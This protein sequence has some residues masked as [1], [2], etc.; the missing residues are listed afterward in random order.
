MKSTTLSL[1]VIIFAL[2]FQLFGCSGGGGGG[3]DL[4][5]G[6]GTVTP[7]ATSSSITIAK[8]V[9]QFGDS[10]LVT[11]SITA[12]TG[13]PAA[14]IAVVF[15]TTLGTLT[16][17]NGIAVT[18]ANGVASV[19]LIAGAN[20]GQGQITASA[21]IDNKQLSSTTSFSVNLPPL[22]LGPLN[23]DLSTISYGGS[24]TVSVQV[25]D[26]NGN[27]Y[28]TQPVDVAFISTQ[29]ALGNASI[30]PIV[31]TVNGVASATYS[32]L[33][34]TGIDTITAAIAG[35]TKTANITILPLNAG[36]ISFVSAAP[37][38]IVQK[39]MAAP[40][41]SETSL[42]TFKVLDT[43]GL[44]KANQP[45][46]FTLTASA[47]DLGG[48]ALL[49]V[50]SSSDINGLV[51]TTVQAGTESTPFRVVATV[52]GTTIASQSAQMVVSTGV[53]KNISVSFGTLASESWSYD[54]VVV[55]VTARLS[56]DMQNPVQDNTAVYFT[57]DDGAVGPSCFTVNG[58]C[59]VNWTSQDPRKTTDKGKVT[60][61][62]SAVGEAGNSVEVSK[63]LIS[64]SSRPDDAT[65]T[66][67]GTITAATGGTGTPAIPI[68]P[69]SS[70]L[71][72]TV[73][74]TNGNLMPSG[75]TITVSTSSSGITFLPTSFTVPDTT[76]TGPGITSFNVGVTNGNK[77][78]SSASITVTVTTPRQVA[79]TKTFSFTW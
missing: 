39:G 22:T 10:T 67:T 26:S 55:P 56:D 9:L 75:T 24:T 31:R 20:A 33:T 4:N 29:A 35:D 50:S 65:F 45:V 70:V 16:P 21:T 3:I 43:M 63:S 13:K 28:T 17:A 25:K 54:G 38:T 77:T 52:T 62:A 71:A 74:D 51:T 76:S 30:S 1:Y 7:S 68:V 11:A 37:T 8:P 40:G 42:V 48:L 46:D 53:P 78:G 2:M 12:A 49:P 47:G 59:T 36:S 23:L 19:Q 34:N 57:T 18:D 60:I 41:Y 5:T 66:L 58:A 44:P 15:S 27:T 32:S 79:T 69:Q 64:A 61:K 6:G 72:L 14:G 73:K